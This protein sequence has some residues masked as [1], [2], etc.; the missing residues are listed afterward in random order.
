M[1]CVGTELVHTQLAVF[2]H[3]LVLGYKWELIN[4]NAKINYLPY[5]KPEDGGEIAITAI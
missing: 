5:P 4:P 3:H 1:K 2:L